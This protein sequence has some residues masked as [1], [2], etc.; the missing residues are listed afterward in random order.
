MFSFI[1]KAKKRSQAGLLGIAMLVIVL[2]CGG[3]GFL[4]AAPAKRSQPYYQPDGTA[5][6]I[7]E[8]RDTLDSMRQEVNNHES[9]I[10][11]FDE[12]LASVDVII[13]SVRDQLNETNRSHK[14]QLKG[15]ASTF[16]EKLASLDTTTKGLVADLRQLKTHANDSSTA[17]TQYKQKIGELE[18]I[19]E[20]Q[21]QNIEH[22]Q[23]AMKSLMDALQPK[24]VVINRAAE[25]SSVVS[26]SSYRVK[27]GDSLEK[28]ARSN[29]T[30]V[31]VIKE[32]NGMTGDRIVVG[33][34]LKLPEN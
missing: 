31:Q 18:R 21:N 4:Q 16:E 20:Q 26:G 9:E 1:A 13:E 2:T 5:T 29:R 22:L 11:M 7:R 14:E 34:V 10:R 23:A 15:N 30:T 32:L 33:K 19:V 27:A 17:L 12:K 8:M 28:I 3:S 25:P 6:A 24:D